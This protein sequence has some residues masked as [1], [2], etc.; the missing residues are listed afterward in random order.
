MYIPLIT[1]SNHRQSF[2][3]VKTIELT[4]TK[5]KRPPR[6]P[7][8]KKDHQAQKKDHQLRPKSE[9]F[10]FRTAMFT[11]GGGDRIGDYRLLE[12]QEKGRG[13]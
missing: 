11:Y 5:S 10:F 7:P 6:R 12:K 4:K 13:I 8:L 3:G 2:Y 9:T 1:F